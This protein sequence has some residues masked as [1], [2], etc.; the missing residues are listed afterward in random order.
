MSKQKKIENESGVA[1]PIEWHYPDGMAGRF[2]NH[3]VVQFDEHECHI[4]FFEI[5]PPLVLGTPDEAANQLKAMK[6]IR[7]D[8]V[9]RVIVS[10]G[11]MPGFVKAIQDTMAKQLAKKTGKPPESNGTKSRG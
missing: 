3:M 1:I 5:K 4:S 7:A 9:A 8:C 2:A 11:R 10:D 6:T